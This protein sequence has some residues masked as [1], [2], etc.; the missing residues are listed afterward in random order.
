MCLCVCFGTGINGESSL[1]RKI[2]RFSNNIHARAKIRFDE[3]VRKDPVFFSRVN[4][5][6]LNL[7]APLGTAMLARTSLYGETRNPPFLSRVLVFP[8]N[9]VP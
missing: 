6:R 2:A 9:S 8:L 4:I 7:H 5:V 1:D 3:R